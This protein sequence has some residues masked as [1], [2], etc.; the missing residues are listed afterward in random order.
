MRKVLN[1]LFTNNKYL[2][3]TIGLLLLLYSFSFLFHT[4]DAF[5]Q[6]LGRHL[7]LGEIIWNTK[8]IP[9]TNLFSYTY[10][11]FPFLNH[12]WLFEVLTYLGSI[13]IGL[14]SLLIIKVLILLLTISIII[15]LSIQ[16]KST[17]VFP[18]AYIFLHLMRG[19]S[20]FRPEIFSFLFTAIT[21][22][23]LE[24]FEKKNTKWIYVLPIVSLL[25]ANSHIYFPLG[26]MLQV[27]FLGNL[28]YHKWR[29]YTGIKNLQN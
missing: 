23:V 9:T 14:Q 20:D 13:T 22:Y 2:N 19:R 28:L 21:L 27:V 12:H 17:F 3:V 15:K 8:H 29:K 1:I 6:D 10:P 5:N 24:L 4:D 7:K 18:F 16:T 25:W 26:I 11:D